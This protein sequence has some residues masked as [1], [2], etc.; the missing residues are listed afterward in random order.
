LIHYA[1][2]R[3][4]D[5]NDF[6]QYVIITYSYSG[7][8]EEEPDFIISPKIFDVYDSTGRA[9]VLYPCI[10]T[11]RPKAVKAGVLFDGAQA[12]YALYNISDKIKL[13]LKLDISRDEQKAVFELKVK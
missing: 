3:F 11:K 2:N 6:P 8:E 4:S 5:K 12:A 10:H 9:A 13:I 1:C 7:Y